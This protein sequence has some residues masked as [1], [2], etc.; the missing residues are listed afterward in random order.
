MKHDRRYIQSEAKFL[1]SATAALRQRF[2]SEQDFLRFYYMLPDDE[3]KNEFLRIASFY[4]YLVKDGDWVNRLNGE[5]SVTDYLTNS[6]KFVSIFSLIESLADWEHQDFY[7]WLCSNQQEKGTF[8]IESPRALTY[9]F[10]QYNQAHGAT[11]HCVAF[12]ES[13]SPEGQKALMQAIRIQ[14]KP[15][16][17]IKRAIQVLYGL[18]SRFVH[19]ANLLVHLY[20]RPTASILNRK[21]HLF[22]LRFSEFEE[23]FEEALI[24]HFAVKHNIT[25][26]RAAKSFA[27]V[28]R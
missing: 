14:G 1:Q 24:M 6:Y 16:S 5:E 25:L 11:N 8:P 20:S 18:R 26:Q 12:F 21:G 3:A 10:T 22:D 28:V 13:L 7:R 4:L 17:S 15:V 23:L 27:L 9:L 2:V 19:D